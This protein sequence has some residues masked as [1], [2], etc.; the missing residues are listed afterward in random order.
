VRPHRLA[1]AISVLAL[2]HVVIAVSMARAADVNP[3][4]L[5]ELERTICTWNDNWA[6]ALA[7]HARRNNVSVEAVAGQSSDPARRDYLQQRLDGVLTA[8]QRGLIDE[9]RRQYSQSQERH[10]ALVGHEF[11]LSY[12]GQ[13]DY[14]AKRRQAWEQQQQETALQRQADRLASSDAS[15]VSAA[16]REL[17]IM[18][19][20]PAEARAAFK[21]S[22]VRFWQEKARESYERLSRSY[23]AQTGR[24]FDPARCPANR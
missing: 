4:V 6:S 5:D 11:D 1:R 22:D 15:M 24:R 16:C 23:E 9:F 20:P 3:D 19:G 13:S 8:A 12:C 14:R 18:K 10:R 17:A 2:A 7:E 21:E